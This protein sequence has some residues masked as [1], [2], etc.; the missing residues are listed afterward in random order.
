M[1]LQPA[2]KCSMVTGDSRLQRHKSNQ[3][4]SHV[5]G[6][7][8]SNHL[9]CVVCYSITMIINYRHDDVGSRVTGVLE[10]TKC[11]H[12]LCDLGAA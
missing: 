6:V 10:L 5:A 11:N 1:H 4:V 8:C 9:H 2:R 7:A 3:L 12:A